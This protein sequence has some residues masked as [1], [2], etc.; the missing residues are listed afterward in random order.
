[1]H[2]IGAATFIRMPKLVDTLDALPAGV[3]VHVHLGAV[4]YVDHA[5]MEALA[6]WERQHTGRDSKVVVEWA[7][8][9]AKYEAYHGWGGAPL[10][11]L[12][13]SVADAASH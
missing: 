12:K 7:E 2:V 13:P 11:H 1:V 6:N 9:R 3:E 4:T 5:C 8:L 10:T